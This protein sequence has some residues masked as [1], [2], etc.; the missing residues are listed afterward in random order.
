MDLINTNWTACRS[1]LWKTIPKVPKAILFIA[2]IIL[3][4]FNL[5]LS[6]RNNNKRSSINCGLKWV[7][8]SELGAYAAGTPDPCYTNNN[9]R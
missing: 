1:S 8:S 5:P 9:L 6:D 7:S 4:I 2:S 3:E